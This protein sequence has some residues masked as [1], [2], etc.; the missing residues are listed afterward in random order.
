MPD[1]FTDQRA[2][3]GMTFALA[4]MDLREQVAALFLGD[5]PHE[6]AVGATAVESPFYHCVSLSH[7][8]YT[9]S[10]CLVFR[11]VVIFQ[12]VPNL[13]DPCIRTFLRIW[14]W[15]PE[16]FGTLEGA[17]DPWRAPQME[18]RRDR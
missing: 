2:G 18:R 5:A 8:D 4:S 10:R 13:R 17:H 6:N 3:R 16:V 9:L 12:V 7:P 1:G 15:L 11:K 14:A